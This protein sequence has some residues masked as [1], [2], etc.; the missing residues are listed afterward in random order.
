MPRPESALLT[1]SDKA[2]RNTFGR[3][4]ADLVVCTKGLRVT[5]VVE[6]DDS[7][8]KGPEAEDAEREGVP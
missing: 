2:I 8:H 4:V 5:A 1:A 6:L 3:K 7:S